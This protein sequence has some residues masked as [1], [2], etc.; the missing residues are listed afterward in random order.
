MFL[1]AFLP[2]QLDAAY[3]AAFILHLIRLISPTIFQDGD[4]WQEDIE[5]VLDKMISDGSLVAPLRKIELNQ[6]EA[7]MSALSPPAEQSWGLTPAANY[8]QETNYDPQLSDDLLG[9]PFWDTFVTNG[10]SGM[11]P[12]EL[13]DLADRLDD[14]FVTEGAP[15]VPT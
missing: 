11:P 8:L 5:S 3:S 13:L 4:V 15:P 14:G 1:D 2:F 10:M 12:Q 7:I 9:D 6:L